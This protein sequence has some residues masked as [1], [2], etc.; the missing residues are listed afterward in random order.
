MMGR[1]SGQLSARTAEAL[2]MSAAQSRRK[3]AGKRVK[4]VF[5][6]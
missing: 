5:S 4:G 3:R 6:S 2:K 1:L